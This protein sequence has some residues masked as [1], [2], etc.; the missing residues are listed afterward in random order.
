[1]RSE[2]LVLQEG[3]G[4]IAGELLLPGN[5]NFEIRNISAPGGAGLHGRRIVVTWGKFGDAEIKVCV[6][7]VQYLQN[8]C[9]RILGKY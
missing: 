4:S 1:L 6:Q 2:I 3:L 9:M 8:V 5:K 7:Y